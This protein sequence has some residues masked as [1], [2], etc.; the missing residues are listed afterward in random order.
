M[1]IK[2]NKPFKD[3]NQNGI[4]YLVATP[5]G[6]IL[7]ISTRGI[8]I[9]KQADIILAEDTRNTGILLKRLDITPK[10]LLSCYSQKEE[11]VAIKI[12]QEVKENN[13]TLAFVSDAG[14]PGISDP[15]SLLVLKA[16]ENDIPVSSILGPAALIQG[17]I[18]SGFDTSDFS[19]YGF[20]PTKDSEKKEFL[21]KLVDRKETLI[22]YE[23]VHRIKKTLQ[24]MASV[25][26]SRQA[27]ICRELSKIYEEYIR[28]DLNELAC[29][30]D[31]NLLG[32][33]VI[34]I[35]GNTSSQEYDDQC[36][37][38]KAKKLE[39]LGYS[40]K[41]IS[42]ILSEVLDISKNYIYKLLQGK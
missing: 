42:K 11:Q 38:L 3:N 27:V 30:D 24:V 37:L 5:I 19:F 21:E 20:L 16:I 9:L 33:F 41:E 2:R 39:E 28:G 10:R 17:L 34:V 26:N 8:N 15:G 4:V 29:L 31:E 14:T 6:N 36:I 22:F 25:F 12:L 35:Q 18:M 40:S 7:D 23:S 1:A 13:L 32:E